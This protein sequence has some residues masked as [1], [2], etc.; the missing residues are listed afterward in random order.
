MA[1][2]RNVIWKEPGDSKKYETTIETEERI[3]EMAYVMVTCV[4]KDIQEKIKNGEFKLVE[5]NSCK[6][7][8]YISKEEFRLKNYSGWCLDNDYSIFQYGNELME[9]RRD[10][11]IG[12]V[13]TYAETLNKASRF[14]PCKK[15]ICISKQEKLFCDIVK[16]HLEMDGIKFVGGFVVRID[17]KIVDAKYEDE[18]VVEVKAST[19]VER[20]YKYEFWY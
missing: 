13:R 14:I 12:Y 9:G 7:N 5:G 16:K 11:N 17:G 8:R 2:F 6:G 15:R 19:H 18:I 20:L 4:R 10:R 3:R 1:D